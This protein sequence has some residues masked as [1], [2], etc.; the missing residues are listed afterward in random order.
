[1]GDGVHHV[2]KFTYESPVNAK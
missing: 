1:M 2:W